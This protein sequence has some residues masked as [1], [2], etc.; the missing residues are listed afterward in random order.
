MVN[1]SGG[2]RAADHIISLTSEISLPSFAFILSRSF[3]IWQSTERSAFQEGQ[4]QE[5]HC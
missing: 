2:G 1:G 4:V 3:F 5:A